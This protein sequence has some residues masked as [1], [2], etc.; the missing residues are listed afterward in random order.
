MSPLEIMVIRLFI[1]TSLFKSL[2]DQENDSELEKIIKD[3]ILKNPE[4][5]N[6]V[7]GTGGLRKIRVAKKREGR[8]KSGG[9]RVLYFDLPSHSRTYLILLYDKDELENISAGQKAIIKKQIEGIKNAY[10][11]SENR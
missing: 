6:I 1:E 8:G 2:L 5:G 7:Q 3:E 4:K 11:K 9:Y 10:K